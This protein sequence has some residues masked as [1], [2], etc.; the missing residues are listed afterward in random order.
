[1]NGVRA[2]IIISER[3]VKIDAEIAWYLKTID[4][5]LTDHSLPDHYVVEQ[6]KG[7]KS[8][9]VADV[10][11]TNYVEVKQWA[12]GYIDMITENLELNYVT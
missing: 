12:C 4:L 10:G 7:L 6:L 3:D 1:M 2:S 11:L 9:L 8:K 5:L